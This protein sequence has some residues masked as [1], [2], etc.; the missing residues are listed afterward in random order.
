MSVL[1]DNGLESGGFVI[2]NSLRFRSSVSPS[3][4]IT[5]TVSGNQTTQTL[6]FWMKRGQMGVDNTIFGYFANS[7]NYWG[8]GFGNTNMSTDSL[9]FNYAVSNTS[10]INLTTTQVFRD[11]SAFCHVVVA[12]DTTQAIVANRVRLY[13]N[14]QQV[15]SFSTAIYPAQNTSISLWN[16]ASTPQYIGAPL[17]NYTTPFYFDGYLA[18]IN[19]VDGLALT[20][21]SFGKTDL[22]T[23]VWVPIRPN[24][25]NYGT[26]GF[27]LEF[28]NAA[29]LGT[30]T[31]GKGNNWTPTNILSTDQMVDSPSYNYATWNPLET[32]VSYTL[33]NANL[34]TVVGSV[35]NQSGPFGSHWMTTGAY[36]WEIHM[37]AYTT[38]D[39]GVAAG[40]IAADGTYATISGNNGNTW[41]NSVST[42]YG[43]TFATG[44]TIGIAYDATN[45]KLY[46]SKNGVWM[47]SSNPATGTNPAVTGLSGK[48][49]RPWLAQSSTNSTKTVTANFG[50]TSWAY[51]PPTGFK[52]L[53]SAN[54]PAVSITKPKAFFDVNTRTGTGAVANITGK[55]FPP[56]FVWTKTR[57]LS[58]GHRWFDSVRGATKYIV[59]NNAGMEVTDANTLTSFNSDGFSL[60]TDSSPAYVND[61][62]DSLVDWMWR[63]SSTSGFDIQTF[64]APASGVVTVN[65]NLGAVPKMIIIACR[66]AAQAPMV[67]HSAVCTT[68][69]NYLVLNSNAVTASL[70]NAWGTTLP[71]STQFQA[72]A[73]TGFLNASATYVAYLWAEVSGFSKIGSYTGATNTFVYTGFKPKFIL[74]KASTSTSGNWLLVDTARNTFNVVNDRL[75]MSSAAE[76]TGTSIDFLSNGFMCRGSGDD[77]SLSGATIIYAA[78]AENPFGGSNVPPATAR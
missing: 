77:A 65:H 39:N 25:Q 75:V 58:Q 28:H 51:T 13:V 16:T 73:G 12:F 55:S 33:S 32:G 5:P 19:F 49:Y 36:Y 29:S 46:F 21:T 50:Q 56:D 45:G 61:S 43:V 44:D 71:T 11:P 60:G 35:V 62:G 15:T 14:G 10:I 3:L 40:I 34:T 24:V 66:S 72:T 20:P 64:T 27:R 30:D 54:L 63:K 42:A 31:S 57:S 7:T 8:L 26:N 76:D 41:V 78:F 6:S 67:Y 69:N 4:L 53:C 52:A 68:T 59:P 18:D 2:K 1:S 23:G 22:V 38:Y 70:T 9:V 48:T 17:P 74:L 37:D 47:A